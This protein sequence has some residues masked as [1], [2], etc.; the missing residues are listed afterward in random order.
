MADPEPFERGLLPQIAC[1]VCAAPALPLDGACA[2]CR[3]PLGE[4]GDPT[5]LPEYVAG[6]LP[7]A[8]VTRAGLLRRGPVQR[9][10]FTLGGATFRLQLRSGGLVLSPDLPPEQW[11]ARMVRA[12]GEVAAGNAELRKILSRAGW[13]WPS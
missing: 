8:V 13:A 3:S 7:G 2:F 10:E 5:G 4:R 12:V 9:V 11:A 1:E 6:R